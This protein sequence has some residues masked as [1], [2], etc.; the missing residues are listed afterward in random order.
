VAEADAPTGAV[1][2]VVARHTADA[3]GADGCRYVEGP[4]PHDARVAALDH[5]GVLTRNGHPVDVDRVGLPSDEYV[6]VPVRRGRR[7]AGHFLV[8]ATSRASY[9]T[10]EQRRVAVLL[11]DQVAAVLPDRDAT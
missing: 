8:T 6:V 3:L 5:E 1:V 11:A 9:P 4:P 10:R 2:D 7:V